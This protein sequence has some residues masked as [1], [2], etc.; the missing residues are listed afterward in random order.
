MLDRMLQF[1]RFIFRIPSPS[2]MFLAPWV[3]YDKLVVEAYEQTLEEMKKMHNTYSSEER[4][5]DANYMVPDPKWKNVWAEV[6]EHDD[7]DVGKTYEFR[8]V[9]VVQTGDPTLYG[10]YSRNQYLTAEEYAMGPEWLHKHVFASLI[11]Y[12]ETYMRLTGV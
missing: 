1:L 6:V 4:Y 7:E 11:Q 5:E 9:V 12:L 8:V 3:G 2:K 10:P